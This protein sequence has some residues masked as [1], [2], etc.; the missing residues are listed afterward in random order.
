M[1]SGTSRPGRPKRSFVSSL[2]ICG[3]STSHA[4]TEVE[5]E[6]SEL[7]VNSMKHGEPKVHKLC[8]PAKESSLASVT[9]TG[10]SSESSI[11]ATEESSSADCLVNFEI[12]NL[13]KPLLRSKELIPPYRPSADHR[14]SDI[15]STSYEDQTSSD[16]VSANVGTNVDLV[17]D[18]DI[19]EKDE[20]P[21]FAEVRT[22]SSLSPLADEVTVISGSVV[23]DSPI[24]SGLLRDDALQET[25]PSGLGFL[26][27]D[28]EQN[29]SG[30][31]VLHVDAVSI[32]SSILS[33]SSS[34]E[35]T[36]NREARRNSRRLFWDAF[37]RRSSRRDNTDAQRFVFSTDD[38]DALGSHDRWLLDF[39]SDLL[40]DGV[41]SDSGYIGSR[42]RN[43][44]GNEWRRH[45]R[46]EVWGRLQ[47]R[48]ERV[49]P[50]TGICP[51]GLHSD[52]TCS[53][54]A[55]LMVESSTRASISRIVML[56]EALFE[57]IPLDHAL[58]VFRQT[59]L[60]SSE[61]LSLVLDEIHRQPV[62]LSLSV[63]SVPAPDAVVDSFP[64]KSHGK[65]NT[66]ESA[67]DDAQCYICL[68]AYEEC[69]KIRVL[70]CHH[71]F[72]MS[73]VDKWLKEI[74]GYCFL[75]YVLLG[76]ARSAEETFVRDSQRGLDLLVPTRNQLLYK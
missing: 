44:G 12:N 43:Q 14:I 34:S 71:E 53:C 42:S 56:A 17:N 28:G 70:P 7:P 38:N 61:L 69:D 27:S 75:Q 33:S 2:F 47:D 29:G 15:A 68:S 8:S 21:V 67:D 40:H 50:Q 72:H 6:P 30:G 4:P 22:P 31:S 54:G 41:G 74:H 5:D 73:C 45:S 64:V 52:G 10:A 9:E 18:V 11:I 37:S 25:V 1:G 16:A 39:G 62:S 49:N 59:L 60:C 3:C 19:K 24:S 76:C 51:S 20:S 57:V 58:F 46:S 55:I 66:T 23:S 48:R 32:S 35:I 26:A 36:S 63:V 13:G 65:H